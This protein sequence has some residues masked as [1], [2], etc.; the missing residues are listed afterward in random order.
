MT[1]ETETVAPA[2]PAIVRLADCK[3]TEVDELVICARCG[4]QWDLADP[5]PPACDPMSYTRMRKRL[6]DEISSAESS[7]EIVTNLKRA[8]MPADPT[9]AKR[10]LSELEALLR[11][12]DLQRSKEKEK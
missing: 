2:A 12:F 5:A 10:K 1:D 3:C 7:F 11:F 4:T 6:V 8:G 9:T